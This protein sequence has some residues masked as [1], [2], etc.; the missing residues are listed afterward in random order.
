M[1]IKTPTYQR[2]VG[3]KPTNNAQLQYNNAGAMAAAN[4]AQAMNNMTKAFDSWAQVR[5]KQIDEDI[6]NAVVEAQT[7]YKK[8]IRDVL[9]NQDSGLMT[10]KGKYAQGINDEFTK[11]EEQIR[12]N[13]MKNLPRFAKAEQTF[14]NIANEYANSNMSSIIEY[15]VKQRDEYRKLTFNNGTEEIKKDMLYSDPE[16]IQNGLLELDRLGRMYALNDYGEESYKAYIA[17]QKEEISTMFANQ[18]YQAKDWDGLDSVLKEYG[19][20]MDPNNLAKFQGILKDERKKDRIYTTAQEYIEKNRA[21]YTKADGSFDSEKA[22]ADYKDLKRNETETVTI[23]GDRNVFKNMQS[24]IQSEMGKTYKLGGGGVG[25]DTTDCGK[26][27]QDATSAAGINLGTRMADGQAHWAVQNNKFFTDQN[28][29]QPGDLVFFKNTYGNFQETDDYNLAAQDG[30]NY[31]YKGITHVGIYTGNGKVVQAGSHGV[32]EVDMNAFK[33]IGGFAKLND[34]SEQTIT[35]PKKVDFEEEDAVIQRIKAFGAESRQNVAIK[36]SDEMDRV[37]N[38][39][40]ELKGSPT[41]QFDLI[42]NSSLPLYT[43]EQ[44]R[45]SLEESLKPKPRQQSEPGV[46]ENLIQLSAKGEL[47]V[48]DVHNVAQY[49][50]TSDYMTFVTKAWDT[51]A[52]RGDKDS[53][54]ADNRWIARVKSES[55]NDAKKTSELVVQINDR[56]DS[57]NLT[58]YERETR[59][60]ELFNEEQKNKGSVINYSYRNITERQSLYNAFDTNLVDKTFDGLE[61]ELGRTPSSWEVNQLLSAVGKEMSNDPVYDHAI[62]MILEDHIPVNW[63]TLKL[64]YEKAYDD[65]N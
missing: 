28:N 5:E 20:S 47:T 57:E 65:I 29:L 10:R 8:Q 13:V 52:K 35:R 61:I 46:K 44:L 63:A 39:L 23:K 27:V 21:K 51:E 22:I 49:L 42:D 15:Q 48:N 34:S 64:Y 37:R 62:N 11:Y 56:L 2:G 14:H 9:Y 55:K 4:G 12:K 33:E 53:Q 54:R 31:A 24:V 38:G 36:N 3:L 45:T 59:A 26:F 16:S 25:Y 50:T 18:A 32:A 17:G 58:G 43:K 41:S 7:E 6:T 60:Y 1:A 19:K 30:D 40:V